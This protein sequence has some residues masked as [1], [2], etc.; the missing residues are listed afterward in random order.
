MSEDLHDKTTLVVGA[1]HGIGKKIAEEYAERGSN[2]AA[3]ARSVGDLEALVESLPTDCVAVECDVRDDASVADAVTTAVDALGPIDVAVNS[4]GTIARSRLHEADEADLTRVVDVNLL[5][6][7]RVSKH[8]LPSLME[9]EGTLIHVSS[10]A[11]S[12]GVP[13]LPTYCASKGGLD[14]AVQQLAVDYGPDGVSVVG[15]AP[16][17]TKT[18]MNEAVRERD[19]SWVE[20]RAAGIPSGRLG[21]P[22]DISGLAAYL[23]ADR[24]DYLTGEVVH[25]DGG[26]TA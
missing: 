1:S 8:V 4:A 25:I 12:V 9:T 19:P 10:E 17:T 22:E 16:G 13:E 5:G 15:I 23:A 2:V 11:G 20:E 7:L 18:S 14:A 21:M 3:L 6:A 24:S 26:S